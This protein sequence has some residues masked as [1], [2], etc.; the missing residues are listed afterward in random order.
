[1]T[2]GKWSRLRE[3]VR[4]RWSEWSANA[5]HTTV[6]GRRFMTPVERRQVI[7]ARVLKKFGYSNNSVEGIFIN[8][9]IR[10]EFEFEKWAP[11]LRGDPNDEWT[12]EAHRVNEERIQAYRALRERVGW[13]RF[14]EILKAVK[15]ITK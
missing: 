8:K 7:E 4:S 11:A 14:G 10:V 2:T 13:D 1:M 5:K 15:G 3:R 9:L 6:I 12:K